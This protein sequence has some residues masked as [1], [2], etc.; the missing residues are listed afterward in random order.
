ME[1]IRG[2]G[3][4]VLSSDVGRQVV[5]AFDSLIQE[6]TAYERRVLDD[7]CRLVSQT[8]DQKLKQPLLRSHPFPFA[9]LFLI[10]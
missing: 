6:L 3:V 8:S 1:R 10:R 4:R 5:Q 2:L 9:P 7:W